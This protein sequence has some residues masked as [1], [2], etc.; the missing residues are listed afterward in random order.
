MFSVSS[1][2][3]QANPRKKGNI[4]CGFIWNELFLFFECCAR[5]SCFMFKSKDL[6]QALLGTLVLAAENDINRCRSWIIAPTVNFRR[7][8]SSPSSP[9]LIIAGLLNSSSVNS[10]GS[11]ASIC[12]GTTAPPCEP[13]VNKPLLINMPR[14]RVISYRTRPYRAAAWYYPA[15]SG[16]EA[17]SAVQLRS[18]GS[19]SRSAGRGEG[20]DKTG[21]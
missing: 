15:S 20:G 8:F 17:H 1:A 18:G 5:H 6:H 3:F 21:Q 16:G 4:L 10:G 9:R 7:P 11:L 2:T 19:E 14:G 13:T 12:E